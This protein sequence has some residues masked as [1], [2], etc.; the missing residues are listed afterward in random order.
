MI[1]RVAVLSTI[2]LA[3]CALAISA[4]SPKCYK[5]DKPDRQRF[6][7]SD[8]HEGDASCDV[9]W[10][11]HALSYQRGLYSAGQQQICRE[12]DRKHPQSKPVW[13]TYEADNGAKFRVN[14][15]TVQNLGIGIQVYGGIHGVDVVAKPFVFDCHGHV[16]MP[17]GGNG[18]N[19]PVSTGWILVPPR[20]VLGQVA[21][22][23]C[24]KR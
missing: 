6:D 4:Q 13:K 14:M 18:A 7:Q 16:I 17:A 21:R 8:P 24:A 15:A 19:G 12:W 5:W 20:S 3:A 11:D 9:K 1:W 2:V 23:V 22:D 10:C